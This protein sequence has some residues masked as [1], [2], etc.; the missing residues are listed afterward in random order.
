LD[1]SRIVKNLFNF[2]LLLVASFLVV[3]LAAI[4]GPFLLVIY[5]FLVLINPN[6]E[7]C[8]FCI[9]RG[10]NNFCPIRRAFKTDKALK[11]FFIDSVIIILVTMLSIAALSLEKRLIERSTYI[12]P[13]KKTAMVDIP[14]YGSYKINEVT[15]VPIRVSGLKTP[16]NVVQADI[17]YDPILVEVQDVI[18]GESFANIFIQK[19]IRNDLGFTR[20]TGGVP[21]PGFTGEEGVFAKLLIRCKSS[22]AGKISVLPTSKVL[23]NDGKGTDVLAEFNDHVFY[24]ANQELTI[25]ELETQEEF[26]ETQVLGITSNKYEFYRENITDGFDFSITE[27]SEPSITVIDIAYQYLS[28]ITGF[29]S[30]LF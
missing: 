7:P 2:I 5:P 3:H 22:G 26:L 30:N 12:I 13:T 18:V 27:T 10:D 1:A 17:Q 21:N 19:D 6:N 14:E 23:A 15:I 9:I 29:Y 20:V 8:I 28:S 16:I 24:I 25:I 11:I 4:F